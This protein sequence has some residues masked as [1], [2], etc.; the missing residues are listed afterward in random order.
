MGK[1]ENHT[2]TKKILILD[3]LFKA[4]FLL[5]SFTFELGKSFKKLGNPSKNID[6]TY[7]VP[8]QGWSS[9]EDLWRCFFLFLC[10]LGLC[11]LIRI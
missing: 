5:F 3:N 11:F 9:I 6:V 8:Y 1:D 2:F 4:Q 7:W 10:A